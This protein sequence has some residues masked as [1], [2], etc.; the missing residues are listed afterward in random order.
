MFHNIDDHTHMAEPLVPEITKTVSRDFFF[1]F[2]KFLKTIPEVMLEVEE[3][4]REVGL[5]RSWTDARLAECW[6]QSS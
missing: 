2:P 4:P 3:M 1:L 6:K 5:P